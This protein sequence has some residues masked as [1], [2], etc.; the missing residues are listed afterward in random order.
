MGRRLGLAAVVLGLVVTAVAFAGILDGRFARSA[1]WQP[2]V[3]A[4]GGVVLG[5]GVT[6]WGGARYA[7]VGARI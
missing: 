2:F 5:V 3:A 6:T 1:G 7:G 4:L